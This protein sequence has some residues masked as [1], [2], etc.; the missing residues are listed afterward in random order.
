M[1]IWYSKRLVVLGV[2]SCQP[3]L[4]GWLNREKCES[5]LHTQSMLL[6]SFKGG[7]FATQDQVVRDA[8]FGACVAVR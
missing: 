8:S 4:A 5:A 2:F 6:I 3:V 1:R 7:R